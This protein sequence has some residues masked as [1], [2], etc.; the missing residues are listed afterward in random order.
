LRG[1]R[2]REFAC[3]DGRFSVSGTSSDIF[4]TRS[5]WSVC[6]LQVGLDGLR[7]IRAD[8]PGSP[9]TASRHTSSSARS[10][11]KGMVVGGGLSS[12]HG[13]LPSW[14]ARDGDRRFGSCRA[15]QHGRNPV[16]RLQRSQFGP[17]SSHELCL[18]GRAERASGEARAPAARDRTRNP[19][20]GPP[21]AMSTTPSGSTRS[22]SRADR[23]RRTGVSPRPQAQGRASTAS[24]SWSLATQRSWRGRRR[25]RQPGR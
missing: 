13:H 2:N 8:T 20:V 10:H 9:S 22:P 21:P 7:A 18:L 12:Q 11:C 24:R 5:A 3:N 15:E 17:V 1:H 25:R 6:L 23:V 19:A 16:G 14:S 4:S